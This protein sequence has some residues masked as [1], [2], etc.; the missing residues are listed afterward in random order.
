MYIEHDR[1]CKIWRNETFASSGCNCVARFIR[2][3]P[4]MGPHELHCP[5]LNQTKGEHGICY[6]SAN[7]I[8]DK[9]CRDWSCPF[10]AR[11]A[12]S[13]E[14]V[15]KYGGASTMDSRDPN[16]VTLTLTDVSPD[17][18]RIMFGDDYPADKVG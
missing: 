14:E 12:E 15:L 3:P 9:K 11:R 5:Y 7:P 18:L 8:H 4:I 16:V 6:C 10:W 2:T 17:V 1:D 13:Q